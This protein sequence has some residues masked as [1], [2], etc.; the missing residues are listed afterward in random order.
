MR[1]STITCLTDEHSMYMGIGALALLIY[2][3]ISTFIF[4]NFQ[5][6][7]KVLDLKYDP[8]FTVIQI[9]GRLLITG[10]RLLKLLFMF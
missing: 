2:Y 1:D 6:Q 3:P 5:F 9:Q 7:N 8:S 10:K 4:P